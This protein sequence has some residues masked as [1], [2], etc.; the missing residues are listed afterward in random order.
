MDS[1]FDKRCLQSLH[2]QWPTAWNFCLESLDIL[3]CTCLGRMLEIHNALLSHCNI[4]FRC[5][6]CQEAVHNLTVW[7]QFSLLT[8]WARNRLTSASVKGSSAGYLWK[9]GS[10]ALQRPCRLGPCCKP[11]EILL[12]SWGGGLGHSCETSAISSKLRDISPFLQFGLPR[13][14]WNSGTHGISR[15]CSTLLLCVNMIW[16]ALWQ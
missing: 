14:K 12:Q 4:V 11:F 15:K 8:S 1:S 10:S 16:R 13:H 7:C 5:I 3:D 9:N 2:V 6:N